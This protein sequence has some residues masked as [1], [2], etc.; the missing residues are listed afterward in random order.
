ML[1]LTSAIFIMANPLFG[2][3][4]D[5][6][7]S[8]ERL[9]YS[10]NELLYQKD[11]LFSY[12]YVPFQMGNDFELMYFKDRFV[13]INSNMYYRPSSCLYK[14]ICLYH[15]KVPEDPENKDNNLAMP[16]ID[17]D[18]NVVIF[19]KEDITKN[20]LT[21]LMIIKY[22]DPNNPFDINFYIGDSESTYMKTKLSEIQNVMEN[23]MKKTKDKELKKIENA[24]KLAYT[25]KRTQEV[26][27][28]KKVLSKADISSIGSTND[29]DRND[30]MVNI[31]T[32]PSS[33]EKKIL[34][35]CDCFSGE[36][37]MNPGKYSI[38]YKSKSNT[39]KEKFEINPKIDP[40]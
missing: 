32:G 29:E 19:H 26:M 37:L 31:K 38:K 6:Q 7:D 27:I 23:Y 39:V 25:Q 11:N 21:N 1:S 12:E 30:D 40:I 34:F 15:D 13:S 4:T 9:S 14:C 33:E 10:I 22:I 3:S 2:S 8:F 5:T 18:V 17:M 28:G 24:M 20:S 35:T 16:C 36:G